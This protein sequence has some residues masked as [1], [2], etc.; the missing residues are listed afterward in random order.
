MPSLPLLTLFIPTF[1]AVSLT[2]GMCMTLALTLGMTVGLRRTFWMFWGELTGVMIVA[3]CSLAG[4][5][6]VMLRY[7]AIFSILKLA[8]G[9]WLIY[10]GLQLCRQRGRMALPEHLEGIQ[11]VDRFSLASQGFVT[12]ISNP[13]GWAFFVSLL[14]PFIDSSRPVVSQT[15]SLVSIILFIEFCSLC[16]YATGGR[17]LRSFLGK[18]GG[19]TLLNRISGVLLAVVG[20]WL[21]L[22]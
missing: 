15:V 2:P 18:K 22:S 11:N 4:A 9:A 21:T 16:L 10:L 5:A 17:K 1:I 3:V 14:P 20:I 19:G 12:A 13:K 7:P 6:T 8:G